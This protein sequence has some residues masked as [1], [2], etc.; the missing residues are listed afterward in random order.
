MNNSH[1]DPTQETLLFPADLYYLQNG[2]IWR[3]RNDTQTQHQ[4]THESTPIDAFDISPSSGM[5]AYITNN[6][7]VIANSDG[8]E[9]QILRAGT[10][11]SPIS[12]G[13]ARLNDPDH[14]TKAIRTPHWSPDEKQIAFIENGVQVFDLRS[15]QVHL[16]WS[17]SINA[18][19][20]NLLESVRSWSPDGKYL[21]VTQ[22]PYPIET[23][24]Q[25]SLGVLQLDGPL[26]SI[27]AS[28]Q[29]TFTWSP[30][31]T[32][33]Y[34]ANALVGS[35]KSLMRC[36]LQEMRCTMIAE[37]EPARWYYYYDHPFITSD[38]RLLVF[39]GASND[40]SQ[41]P[42]AFNLISTRLDG[43][44]R[45]KIRHD[46]YLIES[47]LWSPHGDGVLIVPAQDTGDIFAGSLVW[48]SVNNHPA[49]VLPVVGAS[50]LRWGRL[51]D[52]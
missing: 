16:I 45:N 35:E 51:S 31:M 33:L 21:L 49:Q 5:L 29:V 40:F 42:Q 34:L 47:A 9:H 39:M 25:R 38:N 20:P 26:Y 15:N 10:P 30:A 48:L 23:P 37:F 24:Y 27:G 28:A 1:S 2:Q 44:E 43:H 50:H 19:E 52:K 17:Q 41:P 4:V 8:S 18:S 11:L 6:T 32:H 13:L 22:Y 3:L 7:L 14:I 12:D 46:G 36:D